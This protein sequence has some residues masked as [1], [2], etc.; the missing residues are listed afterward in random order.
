MSD[1]LQMTFTLIMGVSIGVIVLLALG[2]YVVPQFREARESL[3]EKESSV[4]YG[5]LLVGLCDPM[6]N[7]VQKTVQLETVHASD[8]L[9]NILRGIECRGVDEDRE[10]ETI[11]SCEDVSATQKLTFFM[12]EEGL[13]KIEKG[14]SYSLTALPVGDNWC[15]HLQEV[16]G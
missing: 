6:R 16:S 15:F 12:T 4:E 8:T 3:S 2:N 7:G 13:D 1:T 10:Y 11:A 14:K 5:N 9:A